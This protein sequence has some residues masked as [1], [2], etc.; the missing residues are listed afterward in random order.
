MSSEDLRC[1]LQALPSLVSLGLAFTKLDDMALS[2]FF[3]TCL[4]HLNL[5]ETKV[6]PPFTF[7]SEILVFLLAVCVMIDEINSPDSLVSISG[8][9]RSS[10][11]DFGKESKHER[12]EYSRMHTVS[13]VPV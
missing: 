8:F 13:S 7:A 1:L 6:V 2:A 11:P 5:R 4:R 9:W 3:G 10:F 12:F